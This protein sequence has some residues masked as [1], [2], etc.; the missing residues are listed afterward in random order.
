MMNPVECRCVGRALSAPSDTG[1]NVPTAF[2][3]PPASDPGWDSARPI[4]CLCRT[5]E[6]GL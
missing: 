3:S 6:D 2:P 1:N 4:Y 5:L